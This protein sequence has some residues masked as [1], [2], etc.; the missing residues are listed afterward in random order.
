LGFAPARFFR[1]GLAAA[2]LAAV[3]VRDL[4]GNHTFC[5]TAL[6]WVLAQT[7][8]ARPRRHAR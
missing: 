8:K 4:L 1:L 6:A 2:P 3:G 5:A 7:L